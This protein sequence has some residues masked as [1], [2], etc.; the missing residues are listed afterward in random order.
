MS[1]QSDPWLPKSWSTIG[2]MKV[3]QGKRQLNKESPCVGLPLPRPLPVFFAFLGSLSRPISLSL[4]RNQFGT[5]NEARRHELAA[6]T[7]LYGKS[8]YSCFLGALGLHAES[9][10]VNDRG[11]NRAA[12]IVPSGLSTF[13]ALETVSTFAH[14]RLGKS[15]ADRKR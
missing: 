8:G 2:S 15:C 11:S 10:I 9:C 4:R 12:F 6:R 1:S 13:L 7:E 3:T 14:P 5:A